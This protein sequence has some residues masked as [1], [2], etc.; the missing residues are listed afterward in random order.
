MTDEKRK[1]L[2]D[3]GVLF[4]AIVTNADL[5]RAMTDEELANFIAGQRGWY[6][7]FK[8]PSE[9]EYPKVLLWLKSS[10]E[11]IEK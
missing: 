7:D 8:D 11:M 10:V 4:P 2:E 3:A 6:C 1:V 5:I 9:E